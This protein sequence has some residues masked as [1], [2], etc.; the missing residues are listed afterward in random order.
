MKK[1]IKPSIILENIQP[2]VFLASS[3]EENK[4]LEI[5][6]EIGDEVQLVKPRSVWDS[7]EFDEFSY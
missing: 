3:V 1:Y 2:M 4:P 6:D 5:Y 7:D